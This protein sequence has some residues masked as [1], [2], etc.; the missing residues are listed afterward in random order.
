VGGNSA[1]LPISRT[2]NRETTG[3]PKK[4]EPS[5][6]YRPLD[7]RTSSLS[8]ST[9]FLSVESWL[10]AVPA[11][12]AMWAGEDG[13]AKCADDTEGR[14]RR[15]ETIPLSRSVSLRGSFPE[16]C[17]ITVFRCLAL[18]RERLEQFQRRLGLGDDTLLAV[19]VDLALLHR[20]CRNAL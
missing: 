7:R 16:K 1:T 6:H 2:R 14:T 12:P 17:T 3:I 18:L 15:Q 11:M 8:C 4:N 13:T 5:M 10:I 19:H 20:Q 9:S